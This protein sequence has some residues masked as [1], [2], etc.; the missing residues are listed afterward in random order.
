MKQYSRIDVIGYSYNPML[1]KKNQLEHPFRIPSAG[2]A[3]YFEVSKSK[4]N[5]I[6]QI[7]E[8]FSILSMAKSGYG[9]MIMVTVLMLWC[10]K[11]MPSMGKLSEKLIYK[12]EEMQ[13]AAQGNEQVQ[14]EAAQGR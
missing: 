6:L 1:K 10:A 8:E 12:I 9:I 2:P 4:M 13:N 14:N 11:K 5:I 3:A 7:K